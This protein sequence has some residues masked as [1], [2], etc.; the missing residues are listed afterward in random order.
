M[1]AESFHGKFT[2]DVYNNLRT[3]LDVGP[4]QTAIEDFMTLVEKDDVYLLTNKGRKLMDDFCAMVRRD[5][6]WPYAEMVVPQFRMTMD[7]N[8]NPEGNCLHYILTNVNRLPTRV[9][10]HIL[11]TEQD[12]LRSRQKVQARALFTGGFTKDDLCLEDEEEFD[13]LI[14]ELDALALRN[15]PRARKPKKA[16]GGLRNRSEPPKTKQQEKED[17]KE[18]EVDDD[19]KMKDIDDFGSYKDA[20]GDQEFDH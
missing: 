16:K 15:P 4:C 10:R 5:D 17:V 7:E 2:L 1:Q 18:E 9:G 20:A 19:D 6:V 12:L 3:T 8:G 11:T 13:I 14:G